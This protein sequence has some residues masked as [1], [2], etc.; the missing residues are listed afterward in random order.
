MTCI[1]SRMPD[2]A[3]PPR[4]SQ[5]ARWVSILAHPFV[6][7]L[8][9]AA[10]V[11][12]RRVGPAAAARTV[13]LVG[14]LFVLPVAALIA[15]QVRRGAWGTVDAS[16]PRERPILFLVGAAGL[17]ALFGYFARVRA[18]TPLVAGSAGVLAMVVV[19][20]AMTPWVKLSLHMAAAALAAS[21][22]L[23]RGIAIG[24]LLAA[25]LPM[26]GWSRVALGRHRWLEV[27][28]GAAVGACTG[29]LIVRFV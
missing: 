20:A 7:A 9:L 29:A 2:R 26:L 5:L 3:A 11:E 22:L 25:V 10:A 19:C 15:R 24:W 21:V 8:V 28:L 27:A 17:L 4:V 13:G 6:T 1:R 12:T 16:D 18:G 14:A 23:G